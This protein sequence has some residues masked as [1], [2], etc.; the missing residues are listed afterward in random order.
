MA[1][2]QQYEFGPFRLDRETRL[3]FRAGERMAL[4]PK[5]VEVLSALVEARGNLVEKE[6]LLQKI[7]ADAAVEEGTLAYHISLLRKALGENPQGQ[8]FIETIPKRGYRF[9]APVQILENGVQ[10]PG[11]PAA[12]PMARLPEPR[13]RQKR[14][15]VR[16]RLAVFCAVLLLLALA[17]FGA[18]RFLTPKPRPTGRKM[19]AVLPF[20]NLTGDS[21]QEFVSD[22]L[23]EEMITR[24]G[25]LDGKQLGVIARTSAMTY[26]GTSKAVDQIGREL[27]VD[28]ILEGSLRAWGKEVRISAQL[29]QVKDQTHVWAQSYERDSGDILALQSEV[30]QAVAREISLT[31]APEVRARVM[32]ASR[33]NPQV[34][35]LC[36]RGRHEWNKRTEAGIRKAI[37]YFQQAIDRDPSYASGY[38]GLADAYAVLPTYSTGVPDTSYATARAVAEHALQLDESLAQAHATLGLVE[39]SQFNV[40]AGERHYQRAMELDPNYATAHHWHAFCMNRQNDAL[41][42]LERA[43]RLDPLSLIIS[44]DEANMLSAL[45]QPERAI[46]LLQP[47]VALDPNFAQAHRALAVAYAQKQQ[48][49]QALAEARRAAELDPN[50]YNQATLGHLYAIT[51]NVKEARAIVGEV[52]QPGK[53]V[54]PLYLSF[55]YAGLGEK[56]QTLL[57]LKRSYDEGNLNVRNPELLIDHQMLEPVL[58]DP[59]FRDLLRRSTSDRLPNGVAPRP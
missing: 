1:P 4:A 22:G 29:I 18:S 2:G 27:G 17:Y 30:A 21:A 56:E 45:H 7:W 34:Y 24:L 51:G 36:L 20:Q 44:S 9:I 59:Q 14:P 6:E 31:I 43:R 53:H 33:V 25:T 58:S 3:L 26:K 23:T 41:A 11:F 37:Y 32:H 46:S 19:L 47:A 52:V 10:Q 39:C 15:L 48:F 16:T 49:P 50:D 5:A 38:A 40:A 28:Y 42:E 57:L 8:Q 13:V 54:D 55:I 35:E 12:P